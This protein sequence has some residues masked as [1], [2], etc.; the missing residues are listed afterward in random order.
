MSTWHSRST[1][2]G[3]IAPVGCSTGTVSVNVPRAG[4]APG[5]GDRRHPSRGTRRTPR[6]RRRSGRTSRCARSCALVADDDLE[7]GHEERGLARARR[8]LL[9]LEGGVL[10][11]DLPVGPVA[12]AGAG[13]ARAAPCPSTRSSLRSSN[14]VNGESGDGSP[15]SAKTPGSPRWND[16]AQVLPPRSTSTSR[17]SESALTT[18]APTPCRPPDAA[19][20][21]PPNLPPA[22]SLVKTTS[23]PD[24]PVRGSM[25]TGMPR[26]VSCTST[27]PSACRTMSMRVA[28]AGE[29]LVD[30]VVDDLPDAVHEAAR[31]GRADVHARALADRLEPLEHL[32]VVGGVL[33]GHNPQAYPRRRDALCTDTRRRDPRTRYSEMS[34]GSRH[35]R[36]KR[37]V[38]CD[39]PQ[40]TETEHT[41]RGGTEMNTLSTPTEPAAVLEYRLTRAGP[42]RLLRRPGL[43]R[44]RGQRQRA[45]LLRPPRPQVRREAPLRSPPA[46]TTRRPVCSSRSDLSTPR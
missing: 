35:S 29:G 7:P 4:Q 16:I 28:V 27:L 1:S 41:L 13:D 32:K 34:C 42:L 20:E 33:G 37:V 18:E 19:Y 8:E 40:A 14:G 17:R 3:T 44:R 2:V 31:V 39:D 24:S 43:H 46:G 23:T 21:P 22:W 26:P 30:G 36:N 25:S 11:E 12:D 45:A 15:L 5:V 9:E 38:V 10:R 6:C